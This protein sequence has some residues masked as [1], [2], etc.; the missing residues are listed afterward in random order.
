[1]AFVI[2]SYPMIF[3]DGILDKG[4]L[5]KDFS[6]HVLVEWRDDVT[7]EVK[8]EWHYYGTPLPTPLPFADRY[9][10]VVGVQHPVSSW[11]AVV[12]NL[13]LAGT[14]GNFELFPVVFQ[15]EAV[16]LRV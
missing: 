11:P 8:Y 12:N 4:L 5:A 16:A 10:G 3:N 15:S 14:D 13:S 6:W 1:M 2:S 7:Q 9:P